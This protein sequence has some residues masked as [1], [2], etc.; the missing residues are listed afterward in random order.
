MTFP[1]SFL[2]AVALGQSGVDGTAATMQ[3]PAK[4]CFHDSSFNLEA[5]ER[6]IDVE[7]GF[8]G[9]A[10]SIEDPTGTYRISENE[11]WRTP[12]RLGQR[13]HRSAESSIYRRRQGTVSYLYLARTAA[14]PDR[15][16]MVAIMSGDALRGRNDDAALYGRLHIGDPSQLKCDYRFRHEADG[17]Q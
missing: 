1:G 11:I 16:H 9:V 12:T 15:D 2:L 14:S 3:G 17:I 4:I 13:V 8:H 6:I 7:T 10:L 5:G